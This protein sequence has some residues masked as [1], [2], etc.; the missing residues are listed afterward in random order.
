VAVTIE[1]SL[2]HRR[3][4]ETM[5]LIEA[6]R[7]VDREAIAWAVARFL[8]TAPSVAAIGDALYPEGHTLPGSRA[9]DDG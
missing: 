6:G 2:S 7:E 5:G 4:L 8:D 1:V 9:D 3:A